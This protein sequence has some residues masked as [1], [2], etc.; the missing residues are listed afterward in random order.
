METSL[1]ELLVKKKFAE[2]KFEMDSGLQ[3]N[4]QTDSNNLSKLD[5]T[6]SINYDSHNFKLF[7][8][9]EATVKIEKFSTSKQAG[10][11]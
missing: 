4:R 7:F 9:N 3:S 8:E 5:S 2:F 6:N 1:N 10:I 11:S